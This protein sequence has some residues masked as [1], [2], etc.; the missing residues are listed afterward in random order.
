M[1]LGVTG[2]ANA[3][4]YMGLPYGSEAFCKSEAQILGFIRDETYRA[5]VELAK[6]KGAFPLFDADQYLNGEFIKTAAGG[7]SSRH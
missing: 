2:L 7:H 1:G 4:E 3:L 6:E 5:G